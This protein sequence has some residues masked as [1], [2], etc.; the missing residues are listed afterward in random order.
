MR[1]ISLPFR[2]D[3]YGN[4][5]STSDTPRIWADKVR[6]VVSTQPGERVMRPEFGCPMPES[7]FDAVDAVPEL[8]KAD[9]QAAF[10]KWLPEVKFESL[11]TQYV[12]ETDGLVEVNLTYSVPS[13]QQNPDNPLYSITV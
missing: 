10:T 12:D 4:V 13:I 3:D 2:F 6:T 1:A 7:L 5:A 11:D 8:V 9:V